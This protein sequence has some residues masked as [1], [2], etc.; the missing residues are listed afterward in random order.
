AAVDPARPAHVP[1]TI[2]LFRPLAL[3]H[4][5]RPAVA[6][7]LLPIGAHGVATMVPDQGRGTEAEGPPP[8]LHTPA[9]VHVVASSAE[10][11]IESSD[12]LEAGFP[13]RHVAAGDVLGLAVGKEDVHRPARRARHALGDDA[14]PPR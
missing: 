4:R 1:R 13:E 3:Q 5:L 14:I 9:H 11:A 8:L 10:L 2:V 12:R 6:D 7:L